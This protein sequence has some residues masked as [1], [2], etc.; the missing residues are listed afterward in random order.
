MQ[1]LCIENQ[2][3]AS[4]DVYK[5]AILS[6]NIYLLQ[7]EDYEKMS[8]RN[9]Y[10]I[11]GANGIIS[12]SVPLQNGRFQRVTIRDVKISYEE[13]WQH[14]HWKAIE[15]SY[16]KAPFWDYYAP[17]IEILLKEKN[18]FLFDFCWATWQWATKHL[19]L[20]DKLSVLSEAPSE[21]IS[22]QNEW[23]RNKL[24]PKNY[25]QNP[26]GGGQVIYTQV[27]EYRLGF[28]PGL[29]IIDLFMNVGPQAAE[30][31]KKASFTENG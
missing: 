31:L 22:S 20:N 11:A 18:I 4:I 13:R 27:F 25:L 30:L 9:R 12:L 8:F 5:K 24:L 21:A 17:E 6:K 29:S 10:L 26:L 14:L 19:K 15:S 3:F 23:C 28:L 16:R 1:S 7:Y 2:L